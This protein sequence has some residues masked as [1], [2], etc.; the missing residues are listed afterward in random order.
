M[1]LGSQWGALE[2]GRE[3]ETGALRRTGTYAAQRSIAVGTLEGAIRDQQMPFVNKA[4]AVNQG[5]LPHVKA[6]IRK[7]TRGSPD[8]PRGSR[9]WQAHRDRALQRSR[10]VA[11]PTNEAVSQ[12]GQG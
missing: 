2:N 11:R 3:V 8:K 10:G 4:V 6:A 1:K 9:V 7:R 12:F 5:A